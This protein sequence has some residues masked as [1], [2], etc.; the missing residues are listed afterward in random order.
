MLATSALSKGIRLF[1]L[2]D[3][4]EIK[5]LESANTLRIDVSPDAIHLAAA[6]LEKKIYIWD[7]RTNT[8]AFTLVGHTKYC[9]DVVFSPGG[10]MLASSSNDH[11]VIL[12]DIEKAA[13]IHTFTGHTDDVVSL[14]YSND[15]TMLASSG[16]DNTLKIWDLRPYNKEM[17]KEPP[18]VSIGVSLV[19]E[20]EE[21]V[22]KAFNNLTFETGSATIAASS[23]PS[24]DELAKVLVQK[25]EYML[26]IEGHTDNVGAEDKNLA[27]SKSRA[28]AVKKYLVSKSVDDKRLTSNGYGIKRPIADNKTDEGRKQNRRVE[29][30]IVS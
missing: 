25:K 9:N 30:K 16:W 19:K 6:L 1:N 23:F 21:A 22:K 28:E 20:E 18:V 11:N 15:G 5:T 12:W 10:K 4:K 27:L 17:I 7:L 3:G 24:L 8:V 2:A 13:A 29:M 14:S 26:L